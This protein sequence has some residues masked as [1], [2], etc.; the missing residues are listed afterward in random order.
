MTKRNRI[1]T[2]IIIESYYHTVGIGVG[3]V[4]EAH[5]IKLLKEQQMKVFPSFGEPLQIWNILKFCVSKV[6][7]ETERCTTVRV[8]YS[9][10]II[11][12]HS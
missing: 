5:I 2:L 3:K 11:G 6:L 8:H 12:V 4:C 9:V 10:S 1:F 7:R